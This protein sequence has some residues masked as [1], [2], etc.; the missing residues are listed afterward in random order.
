MHT[1]VIGSGS[2]MM[3]NWIRKLWLRKNE[4]LDSF[5]VN[6]GWVGGM[7]TKTKW[8]ASLGRV[9]VRMKTYPRMEIKPKAGF[10][11]SA[12]A[13][14]SLSHWQADAHCASLSATG[15]SAVE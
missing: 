7:T 14:E 2:D 8:E 10:S 1:K 6:R 12:N 13:S 4:S 9:V 5:Y 15:D 3:E 11:E